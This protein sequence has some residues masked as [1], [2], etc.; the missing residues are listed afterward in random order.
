MKTNADI[1]DEMHRR[2]GPEIEAVRSDNTRTPE[3]KKANIARIHSQMQAEQAKLVEQRDALVRVEQRKLEQKVFGA[4]SG[5]DAASLVISRRDAGDR[6]A[7]LKTETE[8]QELL[9]RAERSGDEPLARAIA[10]RAYEMQWAD[11]ANGFL[12]NRPALAEPF[13]Q[14]WNQRAPS[15]HEEMMTAF[16][17]QGTPHELVGMSA[18]EI[19]VAS[20]QAD[21]DVTPS[22][23]TA[24]AEWAG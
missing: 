11:V 23:S 7:S 10:E 21:G 20:D 18:R 22:T 14:L 3:W 17:L 6:A 24:F 4:G 9:A 13:E 19:Q 15:L 12:E 8:A 2:Y 1:A 16:A 5:G